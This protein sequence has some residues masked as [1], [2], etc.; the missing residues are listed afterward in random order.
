MYAK[1]EWLCVVF[2]KFKK[3]NSNKH[4]MTQS[5]H[6]FTDMII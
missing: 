2:M 5:D 1:A 6:E 4:A 3:K